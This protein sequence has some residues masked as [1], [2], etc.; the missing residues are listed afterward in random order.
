MS[1]RLNVEGRTLLLSKS[2][3]TYVA[4]AVVLLLPT[5]AFAKN[6]DRNPFAPREAVVTQGWERDLIK[7]DPNLGQ[8]Q[9]SAMYS[10]VGRNTRNTSPRATYSHNSPSERVALYAKPTHLDIPKAAKAAVAARLSFQPKP[11]RTTS[12]SLQYYCS[13]RPAAALAYGRSYQNVAGSDAGAF[14]Y[15]SQSSAT[16]VHGK[17]ISKRM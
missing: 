14:D 12:T 5:N 10:M 3:P 7:S 4:A 1:G 16:A 15:A 17:V 6:F 8:W 11:E 13:K 9:W 2:L